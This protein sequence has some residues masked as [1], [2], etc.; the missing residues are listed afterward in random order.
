MTT[1]VDGLE[2]IML[3]AGRDLGF[4]SWLLVDQ[5]RI[6]TFATA[7]GDHQWIHVDPVQAATGPFG[8]TIAHG[9]LTLSLVVPLFAELLEIRGVSMTVNYGLD[10]VRFPSPVAVGSRIRLGAKVEAV[11]AVPG[12][13]LQTRFSFTILIQGSEKPACVASVLYRHYA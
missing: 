7:T 1:S 2:D 8:T 10:K 3:L 6:D 11:E 5:D 9:Y 13:G 4:S 12:N